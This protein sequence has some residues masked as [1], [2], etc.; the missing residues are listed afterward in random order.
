[1]ESP[2][3]RWW[4]RLLLAALALSTLLVT[5]IAGVL[6]YS[7]S[8]ERE[9]SYSWRGDAVHADAAPCS[10]SPYADGSGAMVFCGEFSSPT[11][12]LVDLVK[13]GAVRPTSIPA[14]YDEVRDAATLNNLSRAMD[15]R[16]SSE[17][18][19]VS[20]KAWKNFGIAAAVVAGWFLL[21]C[22]VFNLI[23]WIA[24]GTTH[25]RP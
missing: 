3:V 14:P 13:T 6:A 20:A 24:H 25:L 8:Q 9:Y 22:L 19:L 1:M 21:G 11:D 15:I 2:Q 16:S 18:G 4:H 23:L 5:L 17:Y 12:V 10:A 7:A